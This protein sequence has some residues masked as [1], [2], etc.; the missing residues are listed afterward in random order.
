MQAKDRSSWRRPILFTMIVLLM[1]CPVSLLAQEK[2]KGS[3]PRGMLVRTDV[4]RKMMVSDQIEL[5][6]TTE[7]IAISTVA[8]EVSGIVE[9]YPVAEGDYVERG[10]LLVRLRATELDL[11]LKGALASRNKIKAGLGV[12]EKE[13]KRIQR[14]K[15]S[16]S[17]AE[18]RYDDTAYQRDALSQDLV[19]SEAEIARLRHQKQQKGVL[20]PFSGFITEEHTQVGEWVR[21]GGPIVSL[22]DL[23]KIRVTVDVPERH[24]VMLSRD[25][26]VKVKI[27]SVSDDLYSGRVYAIVPQGDT[28]SRTFPVKIRIDN[29]GLRIKGGMEAVVTFNLT[30]GKDA[31]VLQKDAIVSSGNGRMVFS[32]ID[33]KAVP[34]PVEVLGYYGGDVAIRGNLKPGDQVVIRGNERLRPGTPVVVSK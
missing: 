2:G 11:L 34:V 21:T 28:K 8:S 18:K 24:S 33:N 23:S 4:V 32:V 16:D 6:G 26:E 19:R 12:A 5:V 9:E 30:G 29:P 15:R 13:L 10:A 27:K 20:A 7:S 1:W 22:I 25:S 14:L 17:I 31:L 3:A